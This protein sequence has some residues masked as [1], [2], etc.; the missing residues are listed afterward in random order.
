MK[1]LLQKRWVRI[2]VRVL[3]GTLSL[4][5]LA[6]VIFNWQAA[7]EK[8]RVIA[9]ARAAGLPLSLDD[10]SSGMPPPE[11]N[12]ARTGLMREWEDALGSRDRSAAIPGSPE[13]DFELLA[14]GFFEKVWQRAPKGGEKKLDF[15][16]L[17]KDGPYG[18][19]PASFLAEYD[20]RN[21]K[22][23]AKLQAG[24]GLPY[25]RRPLVP[26]G[27]TGS[28]EEQVSLNESFGLKF[29]HLFNGLEIRAEAALLTGDPGKAAESIELA[30]RMG[31]VIGSRG[32]TFS[33][34]IEDVGR[35]KMMGPLRKGID[36]HQWRMGDL[37]RIQRSLQRLKVK[38][39]TRQAIQSEVLT[40]HLWQGWKENRRRGVMSPYIIELGKT[41]FIPW[42]SDKAPWSIP[43]GWFDVNSSYIVRAT[44]DY[45][46]I[47]DR[48]GPAITWWQEAEKVKREFEERRGMDRLLAW[49]PAGPLLLKMG[50]R[51]LVE[52]QLMLTVCELERYY[53]AHG[54]Y[55]VTLDAIPA[56][57]RLDPL[58][59]KPFGYRVQD[60]KFT[61]Y[62]IGPDGSDE[63][64]VKMPK[65]SF[66]NQPDWIW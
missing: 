49:P 22:T 44:L 8:A 35:Q 41:S 66:V 50:A 9:A 19:T 62:S 57:A 40:M 23:I 61:L 48:P 2:L 29:R 34:L 13:A 58:Y 18:Q 56:E 64:G 45:T 7:R 3:I 43:A 20:H 1:Q 54:A 65:R 5:T 11:E 26:P 15:A 25:V 46:A 27:F 53:L 38:E 21:G 16:S 42:L 12:F 6:L 33:V 17:P 37:D 36:G 28:T 55:P 4:L 24:F 47:L 51:A 10:F 39:R 14:D 32:M 60:G 63:G 52:H 30:L 31:E 59:D